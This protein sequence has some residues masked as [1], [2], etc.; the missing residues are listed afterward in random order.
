[1]RIL[2]KLEMMKFQDEGNAIHLCLAVY[3]AWNHRF[4]TPSLAYTIVYNYK[5]NYLLPKKKKKI[6][7]DFFIRLLRKPEPK[8]CKNIFYLVF[9]LVLSFFF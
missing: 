4:E 9:I 8:I 5:V 2:S 7:R 3:L 1:M 6:T